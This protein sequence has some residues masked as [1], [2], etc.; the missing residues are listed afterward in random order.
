ME[1]HAVCTKTCS[2]TAHRERYSQFIER[3]AVLLYIERGTVLLYTEGE[4][5]RASE[6]DTAGGW[7]VDDSS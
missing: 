3:D 6:R 2:C 5:E 7:P 1:R 4:T